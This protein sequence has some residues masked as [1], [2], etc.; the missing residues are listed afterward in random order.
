M[1][2]AR[3][4]TDL[5]PRTH[6]SCAEVVRTHAAAFA[7]SQSLAPTL[8]Y[9][10][11]PTQ[12]G[13]HIMDMSEEDEL[14]TFTGLAASGAQLML[15][16]VG[17]APAPGHPMVPLVQVSGDS[18]VGEQFAGDLDASLSP[19]DDVNAQ[20]ESL[21]SLIERVA[22]GDYQL[23]TSAPQVTVGFQ[24]SRGPLGISL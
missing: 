18:Q 22:G 19:T 17:A 13:L 14:E 21:R 5:T 15:H 8:A 20:V 1:H 11:M 9:G 23:Q 3:C 24:L 16:H 2:K 10:E 12:A 6:R 4:Q 7:A